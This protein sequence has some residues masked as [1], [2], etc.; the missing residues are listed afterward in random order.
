LLVSLITVALIGF[1]LT[2]LTMVTTMPGRSYRLL[3]ARDWLGI[4]IGGR[5]RQQLR[6]FEV[7]LIRDH[8][9]GLELRARRGRPLHIPQSLEGYDDVRTELL[10]WA[11]HLP[12]PRRSLV[13]TIAVGIVISVC[14]VIMVIAAGLLLSVANSLVAIFL[15]L[16]G[17]A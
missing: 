9:Q 13:D 1:L 8:R 3:I 17:S 5:I 11:P 14:T 16:A 12:A 6:R 15:K 2:C 10:R 7:Q 4:E